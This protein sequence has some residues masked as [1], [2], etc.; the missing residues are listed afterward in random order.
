MLP[1][2]QSVVAIGVASA[3]ATVRR[4]AVTVAGLLV[5]AA[6][7]VTSLGFFTVAVYRALSHSLGDVPAL[8]I[9]GCAYFVASLIA[10][11]IVQFKQR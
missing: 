1:I 11:L 9:V 4:A 7:L 2:L 8:L 10:L 5:A 6:L 3:M